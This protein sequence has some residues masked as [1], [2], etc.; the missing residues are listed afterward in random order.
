MEFGKD[1]LFLIYVNDLPSISKILEFYL[2]SDNTSI[3]FESDNLLTLQKVV[4]RELRKVKKWSEAN[5]LALNISKTNYIT[6]LCSILQQQRL[7]N[8]LIKFGS[9]TINQVNY[10]KYLGVLVDSSLTWKPHMNYKKN[11]ARTVGI[12]FKIRH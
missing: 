2:F 5:R 8:S 7:M 3:Y 1:Q 6:M 11:L 12:F 10:V 4:N 9:R